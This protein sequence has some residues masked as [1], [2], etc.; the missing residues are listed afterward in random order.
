MQLTYFQFKYCECFFVYVVVGK[1]NHFYIW[2][3]P[4]SYIDYDKNNRYILAV[5]MQNTNRIT[6]GI[7]F[8]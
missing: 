1:Y 5:S 2:D 6:T 4:N 8:T 3:L 7:F